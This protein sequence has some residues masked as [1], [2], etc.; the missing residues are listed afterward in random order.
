MVSNTDPY[1]MGLTSKKKGT[2][3]CPER[4]TS[5]HS[6]HTRYV[7]KGHSYG[8]S[9]PPKYPL[10]DSPRFPHILPFQCLLPMCSLSGSTLLSPF[11]PL[12]DTIHPFHMLAGLIHWTHSF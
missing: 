6:V 5:P 3:R 12:L 11:P 9:S 2:E 7:P 4:R 8:Y 1:K 10:N